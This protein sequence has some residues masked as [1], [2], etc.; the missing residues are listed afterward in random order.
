M[1]SRALSSSCRDGQLQMSLQTLDALNRGD[2][3]IIEAGTGTGKSLAYLLPAAAWAV[4]NESRVVIA[5]HTLPLQDQL[6]EKELPRVAQVLAEIDL[7]SNGEP[8]PSCA[9]DDTKG[10]NPLPLYTQAGQLV[11]SIP[12]RQRTLC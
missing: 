3:R 12:Q 8:C 6:L 10:S 5:T 2:H 9:G 7:D 4:A 1:P 11:G